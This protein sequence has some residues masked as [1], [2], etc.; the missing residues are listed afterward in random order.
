MEIS[1]RFLAFLLVVAIVIAIVASFYSVSNAN[2]FLKLTGLGVLGYVNI[3]IQNFTSINVTATDCD[4]GSGYVSAGS[5]YAV[6]HPGPAT[7]ILEDACSNISGGD[8]KDNWTNMTVYDP[9]C[10]EVKN[11]GNKDVELNVTSGKNVSTF[12]GTDN[13]WYQVWS[14]N[15]E[16]YSC[17]NNVSYLNRANIS[18][19]INV[20]L[21]TN[22][23]SEDTRDEVY[24]GCH[25]QVPNTTP[26]GIKTDTWTFTA[27]AVS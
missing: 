11:D 27:T 26:P 7:P 4:F 17:E 2:N 10:M 14:D 16:G 22:F 18:N 21:C 23:T 19:D 12:L 13:G 6:L 15:K 8:V 20:T 9:N 3:T 24:V 25:L 1:N 5:I